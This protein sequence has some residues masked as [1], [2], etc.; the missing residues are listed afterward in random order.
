VPNNDL[1]A[2]EVNLNNNR[3]LTNYNIE[4]TFQQN[5][6]GAAEII[7]EEKSLLRRIFN[8]LK[9]MVKSQK[10]YHKI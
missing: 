6:P 4:L 1:Y 5:M 2:V 7:T 10:N 3:L 8:P 9:S